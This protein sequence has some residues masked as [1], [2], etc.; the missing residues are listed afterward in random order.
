MMTG[1][2]GIASCS[3]LWPHSVNVRRESFS[4]WEARSFP[5]PAIPVVGVGGVVICWDGEGA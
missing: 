4:T 2:G 3:W 1:S 5:K